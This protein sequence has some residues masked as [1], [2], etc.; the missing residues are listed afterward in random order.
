MKSKTAQTLQKR[1]T[2]LTWFVL[3]VS[4]VFFVPSLLMDSVWI[5]LKSVEV[6][7]H[8]T[9]FEKI[10]IEVDREIHRNFLGSFIV[11][12]RRTNG[13]FICQ[14]TPDAP[15]RY[16]ADASLPDPLYLSWWLGGESKMRSCREDGFDDGEFL[17]ETCHKVL[18]PVWGIPIAGR[19]I[20]SNEFE[21]HEVSQ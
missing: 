5:N 6:T 17:V 13:E 8:N 16:N 18:T 4:V 10:E 2:P 9:I 14:G 3:L 11:T 21:V 7:R 15:I 12:I 20:L 1:N 19:C